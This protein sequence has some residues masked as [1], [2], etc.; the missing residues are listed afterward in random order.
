MIVSI[1]ETLSV[2]APIQVH[3]NVAGRVDLEGMNHIP[4]DCEP[5]TIL[6]RCELG[7]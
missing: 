3:A 1:M 7:I 2:L 5:S 4:Y 6:V